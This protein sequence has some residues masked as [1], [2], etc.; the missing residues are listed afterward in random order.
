[1]HLRKFKRLILTTKKRCSNILELNQLESIPESN[2]FRINFNKLF[3]YNNSIIF[4]Q[5]EAVNGFLFLMDGPLYETV[6]GDFVL[7]SD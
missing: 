3:A 5:T 7:K 4:Q 1:M 6:G 2:Q